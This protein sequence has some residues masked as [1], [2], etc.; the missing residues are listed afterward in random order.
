[1]LLIL[2]FQKALNFLSFQSQPGLYSENMLYYH[3]QDKTDKQIPKSQKSHKTKVAQKQNLK[4]NKFSKS[5]LTNEHDQLII[6]K[7]KNTK[8]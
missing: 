6:K 3:G 2:D 7:V 5:T 4:R 1:M 8:K